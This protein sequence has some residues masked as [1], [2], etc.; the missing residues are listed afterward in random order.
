MGNLECKS[1]E[2]RI[3]EHTR[4]KKTKRKER[5]VGEAP[6]PTKLTNCLKNDKYDM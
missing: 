4:V 3:S 6:R 1:D 5:H 2:V